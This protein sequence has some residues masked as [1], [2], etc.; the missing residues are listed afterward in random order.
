MIRYRYALDVEIWSQ[1]HVKEFSRD[2][3]LENMRRADAA[4][5]TIRQTVQDWDRREFFASDEEHAKLQQIKLRL[6]S[7]R[8]IVW[9]Q[10]PPWDIVKRHSAPAR[11]PYQMNG[12]PPSVATW[13]ASQD[14]PQ[15]TKQGQRVVSG[16][17]HVIQRKMVPMLHRQRVV[18]GPQ[19]TQRVMGQQLM[20]WR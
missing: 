5:A 13:R 14:A 10:T 11:A 12:R 8:Q 7:G 15:G 9:A 16:P 4:L 1:R 2:H 20:N 3:C 6:L 17:Q 18:S 19:N